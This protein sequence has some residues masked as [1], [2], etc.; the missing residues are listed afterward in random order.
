MAL[1]APPPYSRPLP[2]PG[3]GSTLPPRPR[4][5]LFCRVVGRVLRLRQQGPALP[6][7]LLLDLFQDR[8]PV[9]VVDR[10]LDARPLWVVGV[11]QPVELGRSPLPGVDPE[12]APFRLGLQ[13]HGLAALG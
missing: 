12:P 1:F 11:E 4:S 3:V 5:M 9:V 13:L 6:P 8:L 7:Q 10:H 2:L